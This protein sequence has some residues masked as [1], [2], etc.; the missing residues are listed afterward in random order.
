MLPAAVPNA[1]I[2]RY[3]YDSGTAHALKPQEICLARTRNTLWPYDCSV[4][5]KNNQC[6]RFKDQY[7][8][9][10]YANCP[11]SPDLSPIENTWRILKQRR[12]ELD[13]AEK[14][15]I[16]ALQGY[17]K[18]LGREQ[19]STLIQINNIGNL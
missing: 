4:R 8:I 13:E 1:Q 16:R 10:H 19:T 5:A 7:K 2:M 14:M 6:R 3:G 11:R 15:Y 18:A 9:E 17:E 12:Y